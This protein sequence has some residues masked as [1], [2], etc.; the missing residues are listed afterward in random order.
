MVKFL[1]FEGVV[2]KVEVFDFGIRW[3]GID[4]FFFVGFVELECGYFIDFG[5]V[6]FGC[7]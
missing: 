2:F 5:V 7:W 4:V 1:D 6:E 3:N